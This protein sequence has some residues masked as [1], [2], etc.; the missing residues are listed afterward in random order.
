M[1]VCGLVID[2][3]RAVSTWPV[4]KSNILILYS[5]ISGKD[6]ESHP[7]YWASVVGVERDGVLASLRKVTQPCVVSPSLSA[8][9]V[10]RPFLEE[11]QYLY[12]DSSLFHCQPLSLAQTSQPAPYLTTTQQLLH[13]PQTASPSTNITTTPK[14]PGSRQ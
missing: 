10:P 1:M 2:L 6:A 7:W 5:T 14:F 9:L 8:L 11:Q 3:C 4:L 12:V 13:H